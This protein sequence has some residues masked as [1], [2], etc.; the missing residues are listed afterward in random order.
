MGNRYQHRALSRLIL[1]ALLSAPAIFAASPLSF[2]IRLDP[3]ASAKPVSGRL[4]V[5]MSKKAA[6]GERLQSSFIPGEVW[7]AAME[8]DSLK[9]GGTVRFDPDLLAYPEAFSHA[10]PGDY[11]LMAQLDPNHTYAYHGSDAGD[12]Y[13]PVIEKKDLAPAEAGTVALA[14]SKVVAPRKL[15]DN[16]AVKLVEFESPSLSAFW[17]RPIKMRAGVVL[18]PDYESDSARTFPA[19]Y[20]VHGFGG[21]HS[22]AWFAGPRIIK[23]MREGKIGRSVVVFLDAS[24]PTGHHVFADSVNNGPWGHALTAEFIPYLEKQF[25]VIPQPYARFLTGHS[26]GGWSTLWL[27]VTYPD[28]FGGTWSTSPDPSDF[29]SFTSI[30]ATP[31]ATGNA[32]VDASG[33]P[34]NLIRLRGK[35]VSTIGEFMR[36]EAVTGEYGGQMASFDWVFSPR[37]EDGRPM[38]LFNRS[39]GEID[40]SVAQ[41]W[42]KYDIRKTL[43]RNWNTLAPKLHGKIHLVVGD[44]DNVHLEVPTGMTCDFL[45]SKG[46]DVCEV[47]PGRDHMDLYREY[48]TYPAG[49]DVRIA[50]EMRQA[51]EAAQRARPAL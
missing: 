33:E 17:G 45:K 25:R 26:S 41:A 36:Q 42:E 11:Y 6:R 7:L 3:A 2:E 18:P 5:F 19:V 37:G 28:F 21:D 4:F 39:T 13:S 38:K 9:P 16:P 15:P 47:V 27:Q 50:E 20:N 10:Q 34:L 31:S 48:K 29:R 49:L 51:F 8:I 30:D 12:L 14:L 22:G 40:R 23:Q 35:N 46:E 1:L 24:C 32:Y 44:Q 43:E